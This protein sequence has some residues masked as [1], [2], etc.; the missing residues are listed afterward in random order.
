MKLAL[1]YPLFNQ[2][3]RDEVDR[4]GLHQLRRRGLEPAAETRRQVDASLTA[5]LAELDA[6]RAQMDITTTSLQAATEDLR[7]QQ[8]RYRLG[9]ATI[10]DVLASQEALTQA[11]VDACTRGTTT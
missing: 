7:V 8:E 1:S 2:F 3:Q 6:A 9:A 4:H 5:R 11:E 10:V